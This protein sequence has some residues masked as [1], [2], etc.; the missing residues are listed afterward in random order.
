M[1][2]QEWSLRE[3]PDGKVDKEVLAL[4]VAISTSVVVVNIHYQNDHHSRRH[5][6]ITAPKTLER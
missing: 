5:E 1:D 2:D 4:D 6:E 3:E